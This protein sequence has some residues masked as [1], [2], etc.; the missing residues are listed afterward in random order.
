[1]NNAAP[2]FPSSPVYIVRD[3]LLGIQQ[4]KDGKIFKNF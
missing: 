3:I 4:Q 1:M 2:T